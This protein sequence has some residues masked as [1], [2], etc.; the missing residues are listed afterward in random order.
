MSHTRAAPP[1]EAARAVLSHAAA[2]DSDRRA[3]AVKLGELRHV[4]AELERLALRYR[5]AS[6]EIA[7]LTGPG[8]RARSRVAKI[9]NRAPPRQAPCRRATVPSG[10]ARLAVHSSPTVGRAHAAWGKQQVTPVRGW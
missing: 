1:R 8:R 9:A 10:F 6:D 2:T 3:L 5:D 4:V 7:R